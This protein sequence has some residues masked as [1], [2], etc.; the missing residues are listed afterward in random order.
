M[1]RYS[2]PFV[3]L[4]ISGGREVFRAVRPTRNTHGRYLAV[5]GPFKTVGGAKFMATA[6]GNNPKIK[7]VT[8]AE[9][10]AKIRARKKARTNKGN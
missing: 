4:T 3:G 8:D 5:V 2:R 7:C 10:A 6:L 9:K 1:R